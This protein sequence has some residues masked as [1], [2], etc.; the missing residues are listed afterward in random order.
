MVLPPVFLIAAFF[1]L[2]VHGGRAGV[3]PWGLMAVVVLSLVA[4][5]RG[6]IDV[7]Q[8]APGVFGGGHSHAR[9][10]SNGDARA[11]GDGGP[12]NKRPTDIVDALATEHFVR[13]EV[14]QY[15]PYLYSI[16]R[17][18][19]KHEWLRGD[20]DLARALLHLRSYRLTDGHTVR[21]IIQLLGE[22][23]RRYDRML[24]RPWVVHL[25]N[26]YTLLHD[27]ALA[28]LNTVHELHFAR[29]STL[30]TGLD[31][32]SREIQARTSRM[33]RVLRHKYPEHLRGSASAIAGSAPRAHDPQAPSS[34]G[35][36]SYAIFV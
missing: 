5:E 3:W 26:E 36:A 19:H 2:A 13:P 8:M 24:N 20:A 4:H 6:L 28:V 33:L 16:E 25:A 18:D 22:F 7:R 32:V 14:K 23:Y 27:I 17:L 11:H 29:P 21:L 31:I 12:V 35:N 10:G 15:I 34:P 30:N 1:L 9:D